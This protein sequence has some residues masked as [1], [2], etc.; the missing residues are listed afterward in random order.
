M[1]AFVG[2]GDWTTGCAEGHGAYLPLDLNY[3]KQRLGLMLEE[4]RVSLILTQE[5]WQKS[6]PEFNGE[7][8][9][10]DSELALFGDEEANNLKPSII[11]TRWLLFSSRQDQ[12][13]NPK[14][15]W[16]RSVA[17]STISFL[18]RDYQISDADVV[19][20]TASLSFDASVRDII[21]PIIAGA[22]LVL[23]ADNDVKDP[24][25]LLSRIKEH[26]V[27]CILSIVPTMLRSL[28]DAAAGQELQ[29]R[30]YDLSYQWGKPVTLRMRARAG[31]A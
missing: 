8:L 15:L 19:L 5:R 20:Q 1:E 22:K 26:G 14:E 17:R 31:V 13:E 21:G 10:L 4:T 11:L 2:D 24:F 30:H 25:V 27:T 18:V 23:V 12:P 16:R 29:A 28:T 9:C 7:V 6:L 3:P